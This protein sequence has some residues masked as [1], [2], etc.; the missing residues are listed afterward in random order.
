MNSAINTIKTVAKAEAI[1]ASLSASYAQRVGAKQAEHS[2]R[3]FQ[4]SC[5]FKVNGLAWWK[6]RIRAMAYNVVD[7]DS[8]VVHYIPPSPETLAWGGFLGG[9]RISYTNK[10]AE[11][12]AMEMV[13]SRIQGR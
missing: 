5:E 9:E 6:A 10:A 13:M 8:R 11:A 7:A 4:R 2:D 1:Y 12:D 3:M